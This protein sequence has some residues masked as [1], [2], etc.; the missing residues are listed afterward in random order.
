M[1]KDLNKSSFYTI[2]T[3]GSTDLTDCL[4]IL[5]MTQLII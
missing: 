1:N 3:Q 5:E 4:L 2:F